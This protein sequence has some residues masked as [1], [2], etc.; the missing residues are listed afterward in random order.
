MIGLYH[1]RPNFQYVE[2]GVLCTIA[3]IVGES[4]I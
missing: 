4:Y 1:D 2:L 3:L